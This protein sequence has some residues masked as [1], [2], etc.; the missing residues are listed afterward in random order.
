MTTS[1]KKMPLVVIFGR[2]NVGKSTLFNRLTE[3]EKALTS[4][5]EGTTRDS[6]A[7]VVEWGGKKFELVD[8]G[9]I[10]DETSE[11]ILGKKKIK[12]NDIDAKVQKQALNFIKKSDLVLFL[13]DA[14]TGL[15]PQDELMAK[16]LKKRREKK[17]LLV[18]NKVDNYKKVNE[19]AQFH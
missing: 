6:N 10:I 5:T 18:A 16:Y 12:A 19:I 4:K 1:T 2:T 13:A 15:L 9:G 14:K 8:T 7:D 17:V 3:S 11:L